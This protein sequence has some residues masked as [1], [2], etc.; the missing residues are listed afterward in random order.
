MVVVM[1]YMPSYPPRDPSPVPTGRGALLYESFNQGV[2][3]SFSP[4]VVPYTDR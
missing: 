1:G 4:S 3:L 2:V